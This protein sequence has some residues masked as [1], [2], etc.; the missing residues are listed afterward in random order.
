MSG[1]IKF[2]SV[3]VGV[4]GAAACSLMAFLTEATLIAQ[5]L[6]LLLA[7][8][9]LILI[10]PLYHVGTILESLNAQDEKLRLLATRQAKISKSESVDRFSPLTKTSGNRAPTGAQTL[11]N[12]A[13]MSF[14]NASGKTVA[15]APIKED[16][17]SSQ[18]FVNASAPRPVTAE[19]EFNILDAET[20]EVNVMRAVN[21]TPQTSAP[22]ANTGSFGVDRVHKTVTRFV[23]IASVQ[24]VAAGGLHSVA[25]RRS[26]YVTATGYNAYGQCDVTSW[27]DIVSVVAGN[28]HTIGLR[29]NGTCVACGYSG[30]GQCDVGSW[31]SICS[32]ATGASHTVGLRE[33]GTCVAVG[34]NTYGQCNVFDWTDIMAISANANYTVGLR[35]DG[36]LVAVGANTDGQW[37]AIRWGGIISVAAGGLHT[38]GLRNDGT[39][40]SVGNN[41]NGQCE[42]SRWS[43]IR[44]VAAGNF[45]TVG[46]REDGTCIAVGHN[47]YGQC[48]VS[49]WHDIIAIVAG[50]NHTLALDRGGRVWAAGDTTYGQCSVKDF[51]DIKTTGV[52]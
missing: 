38:I 44:S 25:V 26:G 8:V 20:G 42:V 11:G 49:D 22:S 47:G 12:I 45:H 43:K 50:R 52:Q 46:L 19:R 16:K 28:H 37:S 29:A 3:L 7:I 2:L 15:Y 36:T 24:T 23:P 27:R 35:A 33:D 39:C 32:I 21:D 30:Y 13:S 6:W 18:T 10:F 40:V 1:T 41:A 5:I 51:I 17:R 4:L 31:T 14:P 48:N 9:C 34:D